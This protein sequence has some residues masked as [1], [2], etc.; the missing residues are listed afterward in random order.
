MKLVLLLL[1]T[2]VALADELKGS[3]SDAV[4]V[5]ST[6]AFSP[7]PTAE[8]K[9]T[10]PDFEAALAEWGIDTADVKK[11]VV[12]DTPNVESTV[13]DIG[14]QEGSGID[15]IDDL[16]GSEVDWEALYQKFR[17]ASGVVISDVLEGSGTNSKVSNANARE[18]SAIGITD[19]LDGS[20]ADSVDWS[21]LG[22]T[23]EGSG[24]RSSAVVDA[25]DGSGVDLDEVTGDSNDEEDEDGMEFQSARGSRRK[26]RK[27]EKKGRT[28]RPIK[29]RTPTTPRLD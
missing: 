3:G 29:H 13:Q 21:E 27:K 22:A 12:N 26:D 5:E 28:P 19:I 17:K 24:A 15:I 16:D 10:Q 1:V 2:T 14:V 20:G 25:I 4:N 11:E 8:G 6:I 18:G 7:R 9:T 23:L